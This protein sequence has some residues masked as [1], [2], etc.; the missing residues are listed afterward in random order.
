MSGRLQ[1][2]FYDLSTLATP[3]STI[4]W[5]IADAVRA[6]KYQ[7]PIDWCPYGT[8][9]SQLI[10]SCRVAWRTAYR[11]CA[12]ARLARAPGIRPALAHLAVGPGCPDRNLSLVATKPLAERRGAHGAM[13]A[14]R[15]QTSVAQ[16]D[17]RSGRM[18]APQH[19]A[20]LS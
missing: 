4:A 8:S 1:Y 6:A 9:R 2:N 14:D 3:G 13:L 18:S 19:K 12:E 11:N 7:E 5:V 15:D 20:N 17:T 16:V 10:R